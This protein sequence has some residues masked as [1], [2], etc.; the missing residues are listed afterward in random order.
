MRSA[1]LVIAEAAPIRFKNDIARRAS[2]RIGTDEPFQIKVRRAARQAQ[3]FNNQPRYELAAYELQRLLFDPESEVVPPT[4]LRSMP[5]DE[6]RALDPRAGETFGGTG[7][8]LFIVQCWLKGV[9]PHP[10]SIDEARFAADPAYARAIS[11]LNVLTYLIEHKDSNAGNVML[12]QT[13]GA[14]RAWAIDNGVAF[15][16]EESDVGAF[17]KPLRVPAIDPRLHERLKS[18]DRATLD[19]HLGVVAEFTLVDGNWVP[20]PPEANLGA[21]SGVRREGNVLQLGLTR[22]EIW[23]VH[24]RVEALR[25]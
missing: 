14:V 5:L 2:A 16:S 23:A 24:R 6:F 9:K 25:E 17:W 13:D 12:A 1:E 7:A 21:M 8:S 11:N 10:E 20:R 18:I 15:E 3:S 4:V 19:R 22:K